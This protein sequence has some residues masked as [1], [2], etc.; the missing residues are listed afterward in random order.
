MVK[1]VFAYGEVKNYLDSDT[2]SVILFLFSNV[3]F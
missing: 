3:E 1:L 2:V